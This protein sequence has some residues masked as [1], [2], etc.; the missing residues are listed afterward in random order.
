MSLNPSVAALLCGDSFVGGGAFL[1]TRH[2]LVVPVPCFAVVMLIGLNWTERGC[3]CFCC[4]FWLVM[5][6]QRVEPTRNTNMSFESCSGRIFI[7]ASVCSCSRRQLVVVVSEGVSVTTVKC[8]V[9]S[10]SSVTKRCTL[11]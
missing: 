7:T 4:C 9:R 11:I 8:F 6:D 5:L 10:H 3:C 1:H 2:G